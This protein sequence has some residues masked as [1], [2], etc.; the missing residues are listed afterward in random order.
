[1]LLQLTEI[2]GP[3]LLGSFNFYVRSVNG[4][5]NVWEIC[6]TL[7]SFS[8]GQDF[9]VCRGKLYPVIF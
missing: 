5:Y 6:Q 3:A 7:K 2:I 9:S 8:S 4:S 1:M